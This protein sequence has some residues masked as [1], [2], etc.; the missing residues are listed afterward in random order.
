[1][2]IYLKKAIMHVIDREDGQPILAENE[3]DLTVEYSRKYLINKIRKLSSAKTKVGELL[4]NSEFAMQLKEIE[5]GEF[6]TATKNL[7]EL[8]YRVYSESEEA[9]NADLIFVLYE[10]DFQ[11]N[12]R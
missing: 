7:A 6:V 8:W 4:P 5:T 9:P 12:F 11:L 10:M 1:M 3:M 2:D